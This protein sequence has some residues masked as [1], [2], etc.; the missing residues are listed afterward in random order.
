[1]ASGKPGPD[2]PALNVTRQMLDELEALMERMLAV[3]IADADETAT[4]SEAI[5]GPAAAAPRSRPLA[6]TLTLLPLPEEEFTDLPSPPAEARSSVPVVDRPHEGTNPSHLPSLGVGTPPLPEATPQPASYTL[7]PLP[8]APFIDPE[9][10]SDRVVP[11]PTNLDALLADLPEPPLALAGWLILPVLW[12]NRLFDRATLL[13]GE[14]G[15]WLRG[16]VGRGAVGM[17]GLVLFAAAVL[18]L[19]R[20]W[21]GWTW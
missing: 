10:L 20:D 14:A 2:P 1:M 21:L 7:P 12:G 18:W 16:P 19:A 17:T 6:A 4:S 13:L 5:S 8:D 3:P 9:P 15:G 11:P